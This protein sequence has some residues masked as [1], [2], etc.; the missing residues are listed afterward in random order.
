MQNRII[1]ELRT[2]T[3]EQLEKEA[4]AKSADLVKLAGEV[5]LGRVK[6]VRQVKA[7]RVH[8]ARIKTILREMQIKEL[9]VS[10]PFGPELKAEGRKRVEP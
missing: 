7:N 4:Q 10:E 6:N 8:I 2:K 5:S 9:V 1:K 3:K